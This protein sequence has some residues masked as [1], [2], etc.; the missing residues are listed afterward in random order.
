MTEF[1][2]TIMGKHFYEGTMPRLVAVLERIAER[3]DHPRDALFMDEGPTPPG[4]RVLESMRRDQ[5]DHIIRDSSDLSQRACELAGALEEFLFHTKRGA[6]DTNSAVL[7]KVCKMVKKYGFGPQEASGKK[8]D[9]I[10]TLGEILKLI[11]DGARRLRS[12]LD[13]VLDSARHTPPEGMHVRWRSALAVLEEEIGEPTED[14]QEKAAAIF[15]GEEPKTAHDELEFRRCNA[16]VQEAQ[17]EIC[18][19]TCRH[20]F[21]VIT[22]LRIQL[23]ASRES[24]AHTNSRSLKVDP[25]SVINR[26]ASLLWPHGATDHEWDSDV[27]GEIGNVMEEAG[28]KP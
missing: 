4:A 3:L 16:C 23:D 13:D 9:L 12:R 10:E 14:W 19:D 15:A 28:F 22:Q 5:L 27:L 21:N 25:W 1:F 18:C 11:P 26:I 20:N 17:D 7:H 6:N 2:Q 24:V 8:R